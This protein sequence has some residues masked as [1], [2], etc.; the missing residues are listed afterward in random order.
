MRVPARDGIKRV[1]IIAFFFAASAVEF[2]TYPVA[3]VVEFR[4][5]APRFPTSSHRK[6]FLS[7]RARA[8]HRDGI[9]DAIRRS[10]RVFVDRRGACARDGRSE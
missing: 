8:S 5:Q 10:V 4:V 7:A 9:R 6:S 3:S 1:I 2:G